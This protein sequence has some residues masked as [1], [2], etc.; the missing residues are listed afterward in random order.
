MILMLMRVIM[1]MITMSSH[2]IVKLVVREREAGEVLQGMRKTHLF[3]PLMVIANFF[4]IL[5][6]KSS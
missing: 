2:F 6:R 5:V 3:T 4:K 1:M